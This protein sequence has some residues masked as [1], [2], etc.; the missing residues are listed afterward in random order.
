MTSHEQERAPGTIPRREFTR[1]AGLATLSLAMGG[2]AYGRK[3]TKKPNIILILIDDMGWRDVGFMGSRY[4]RT[5]NIDRLSREGMIF[6]DAYAAAPN[7]APSRACLLTG[8]Y[9]PRHGIYTVNSSERGNARH[10]K[11]IPVPNTTELDPRFITMVEALQGAGYSSVSIG[12]WHLGNDPGRGP[13]S[14]GFDRNIGGGIAG[15]PPSH[16]SPYGLRALPDGPEGEYLTDRLTDEA[17]RFIETSGEQPFFLYLTHYAVHTPVQAPEEITAGYRDVPPSGGQ[18]DPVYAAMIE[19]V[20]TGIGRLLDSLDAKGQTDNT[21]VIFCSDNGGHGAK[22][23]MEP[24]RGSKGMLY[25]GGIRSPMIVRWPEQIEAGSRCSE[26]VIMVDLLPT[27]L[28]MAEVVQPAGQMV[29]GLSLLPLLEGKSGFDRDAI[30]WHFPAY[31]EA[32]AGM[33]G[34][35]RTT[36]AGAVRSGEWKLIEFFEDGNLELY[37]LHDDIGEEHDLSEAQSEKRDELHRL[38]LDWRERTGAPVPTELNP[39]FIPDS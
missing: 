4:Y 39:Q 5:P 9:T 34:H 35:W 31:L 18:G 20:D 23:S 2:C 29:D 37:N 7:C 36:P 30:F 38:M 19:S 24:L 6:T 8:L 17:I 21:V 33:E 25:E 12:K 11:L 27:I 22:T 14:Q 26:P 28:E 1:R 16:F 15:H 13:L 3:V 10:R 32:Y